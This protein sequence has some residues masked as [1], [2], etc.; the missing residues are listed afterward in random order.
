MKRTINLLNLIINHLDTLFCES[1]P[2]RHIRP[3]TLEL[4][5][6]CELLLGDICEGVCR[7]SVTRTNSW[8]TTSIK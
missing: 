8:G 3:A 1:L 2:W 6:S 7:L 5:E 4:A